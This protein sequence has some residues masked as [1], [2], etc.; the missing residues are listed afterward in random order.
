MQE[1]DG[2]IT[3]V[4]KNRA[5]TFSKDVCN[6]IDVVAGLGV[7]GDAH[8][9]ELVKHRSRVAV[10]P[11]QPNFRQVHLIHAE[12]LDELINKG[13]KVGPGVL[14]EN[15]TTRAV[16]LLDLPRDTILSIGDT[17]KI[18][19]TGLRNP[20]KQL[21]DYQPGLMDAV[22]DKSPKGELIRKCGEM[23]IVLTSGQISA[24]DKVRIKLPDHPHQKLERV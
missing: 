2:N 24:G 15:I 17:A 5:H 11:A 6:T 4:S 8:M 20:C 13:F 7:R 22:L 10:D 1:Q 21:N 3:S 23:G 9:G 18:Q 16:D 12:L 14:G 19:I